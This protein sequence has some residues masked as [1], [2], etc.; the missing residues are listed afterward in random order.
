MYINIIQNMNF[1]N[2]YN[3]RYLLASPRIYIYQYIMVHIIQ[4]DTILIFR[5][6]NCLVIPH[7]SGSEVINY[8]IY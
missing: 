7:C 3:M 5:T 1:D 4:Y 6:V 2:H 8:Y